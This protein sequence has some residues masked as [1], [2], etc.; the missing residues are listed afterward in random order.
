L[1][2]QIGRTSD[3]LGRKAFWLE[4]VKRAAGMSSGL[5]NVRN[6]SLLRGRPPP[7]R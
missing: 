7:K 4:F 3:G 1:R 2:L 6:W 5:R